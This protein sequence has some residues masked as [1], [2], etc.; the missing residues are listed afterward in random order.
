MMIPKEKIL[1][2]EMMKVIIVDNICYRFLIPLILILTT[3]QSL[4]Q[5][6]SE[7][8]GKK[9]TFYRTEQ[10]RKVPRE[11]TSQL[12]NPNQELN[13]IF[14]NNERGKFIYVKGNR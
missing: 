1:L 4:P 13:T 11:P 5:L 10:Q 14:H 9:N 2:F 6:W 7:S 12:E 8:S 3:K